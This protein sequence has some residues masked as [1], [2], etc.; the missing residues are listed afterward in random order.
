MHKPLNIAHRG[1]S[2]EGLAP[3]NTLAAF[4]LALEHSAD[5]VELD[6]HRT[7]DGHVVVIH[8]GTLDRTTNRTGAIGDL[9]LRDLIEADAGDGERIPTLV[10]ALELIRGRAG[11]LIEIKPEDITE[12]VTDMIMETEA[13][14][15]TVIQSFHPQVVADAGRLLP[16]VP[17]GLLIGREGDL[18]RLAESVDAGI[19]VPS[20]TLVT[21]TLVQDVHAHG[22]DFY[23]YTVDAE[24]D[25]HR[26]IELGVDG[27]ITN[28]PNR[29]KAVISD[30]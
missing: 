20:Y 12:T 23:T 17:R 1:A 24:G 2:G 15:F 25:M 7:K 28:Y 21:E 13:T 26:M 4:R 27:I 6:V 16:Q 30:K 18:I 5:L 9:T 11:V 14:D 10:E 19:V 8:D 22:L 29:L 3:G